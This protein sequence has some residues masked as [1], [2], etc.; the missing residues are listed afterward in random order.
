MLSN[1]IKVAF[2]NLFRNSFYTIINIIGLTIGL[3]GAILIGLFIQSELSYDRYHQD[4]EQIYRLESHFEI[5]GNIDNFAVTSLPLATALQVEFPDA[6]E[7]ITRL[8]P[9]DNNLFEYNQR[10][11]FEDDIFFADSTYFDLFTHRFIAGDPL[12]AL[13]DPNEMV[14]TKSMSQRIFGSENPLGKSIKSGNGTDYTITG[15]IEDLPE[16]THLRFQGLIS[17]I[18]LAEV[19]GYEAFQS[20][21]GNL[22]WNVGFFSFIK[23]KPNATIESITDNFPAVYQKY[24]APLGDQLNAS[25]DLIVTPLADIHL[26]ATTSHDLPRG[27]IAYIYVFAV[28]ALFLLLIGCINYMNLATARSASRAMEVGIRKVVGAQ[29]G[30]LQRQFIVESLLITFMAMILAIIASEV[31]LPFFSII[32]GKALDF[33]IFAHLEYLLVIVVISTIVGFASGSYPAFYLASFIPAQVLKT[34]TGRSKRSTLRKV[35]VLVQFSISIV[36]IIGTLTVGRQLQYI[37]N[38]DLGYDDENLMVLTVRDESAA[39]NLD[40]CKDKLSNLPGVVS[41]A[42]VSAVPGNINSMIVQRYETDEGTMAEKAINF[43]FVDYDFM[44]VMGMHLVA[45]RQYDRTTPTDTEDAMIINRAMAHNLG[46]DGDAVGKRVDFGAGPD[47]EAARSTRVIGVVDNFHYASL[48]NAID[49]LM[50]VLAERTQRTFVVRLQS[51]NL[52]STIEAIGSVWKEFSP[53]FPYEYDFLD[54]NIQAMYDTDRKIGTVFRGMSILCIIIACLGLF[55]LATFT[56]E[57]R[58][59]EIGIRK[60]MG[61]EVSSITLL[62]SS[63]FLKWVLLANCIAWPISYWA[64][65]NWLKNFAFRINLVQNFWIFFSAAFISLAI[66]MLTVIFQTLKAAN[67]NPIKALRYE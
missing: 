61:A 50:L 48:H 53:D 43:A 67:Q 35:L 33:N 52:R 62:L 38:K 56:A 63:E 32:S 15:I 8:N 34:A 22:F 17:M 7:E 60:V 25:F 5:A 30:M 59:R 64:L 40:A 26:H 49:P 16:N 19:F 47:G 20:L 9:M 42:S 11:F 3:T 6:I 31:F 10:K 27:N 21:D 23:L 45:G 12:N 54:S 58:R 18:S 44:D 1:F 41:I 46:W 4:H 24:M 51:Q 37:Q 65:T 57:Q 28:V 13:N 2:R 29:K 36:M 39:R 66:A 55:G 14:L